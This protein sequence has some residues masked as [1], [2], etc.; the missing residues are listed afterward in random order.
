[1]GCVGPWG[2]GTWRNTGSSSR[3][4]SRKPPMAGRAVSVPHCW[5]TREG[6]KTAL[7]N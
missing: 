6:L 7:E 3:P 4:T 1:M 2:A 5:G